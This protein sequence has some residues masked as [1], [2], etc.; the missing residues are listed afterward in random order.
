MDNKADRQKGTDKPTDVGE[1]V[2]Y[3]I[4]TS[5]VY[6]SPTRFIKFKMDIDIVFNRKHFTQE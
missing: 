5:L 1:V 4:E 6:S 3:F 2:I